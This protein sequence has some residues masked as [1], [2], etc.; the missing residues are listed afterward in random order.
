MLGGIRTAEP[1]GEL[2]T[3]DFVS[4]SLRPSPGSAPPEV[5]SV[6]T[7]RFGGYTLKFADAIKC[8]SVSERPYTSMIVGLVDDEVW[9]HLPQVLLDSG[10]DISVL[11]MW[12]A[13]ALGIELSGCETRTYSGVGGGTILG[14]LSEVRIGITHLGG[15][16]IDVDGYILA[17]NG[18]SFLPV[19][20]VAFVDADS[21]YILGRLDVFDVLDMDFTSD[22]VTIRVAD[23]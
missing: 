3:C 12:V 6:S 13:D 19:I 14:Y 15:V 7:V 17:G 8:A 21:P 2:P 23:E 18:V 20:S 22:T 1:V 11:P 4:V 9:L 16:E 10:A 5:V